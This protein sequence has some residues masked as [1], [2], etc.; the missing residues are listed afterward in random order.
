MS[1]LRDALGNLPDAVFVDVHEGAD[2]Y[3][4]VVDVAGV[5]PSTVDVSVA[6]RTV[7]IEAHRRK[8]VPSAFEYRR[9]DRSLFVDAELPLPSDTTADG[10]TASV[11]NGVLTVSLPKRSSSDHHVPVE[12]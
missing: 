10:A 8:S 9:E 7:S 1:R 2:A 4:Y 11:S 3:R 6:G 12:G 5:T